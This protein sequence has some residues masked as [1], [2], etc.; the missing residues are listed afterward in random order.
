MRAK[1]FAAIAATIAIV[2]LLA[3]GIATAAHRSTTGR[4]QHDRLVI[5]TLSLPGS[6]GYGVS[7][8]LTNRRKLK[9]TTFPEREQILA[10]LFELVSTEYRLDA[11][12][13]RGSNGIQ[14]SV[15]RF[16]RI[17]LRFVP[18]TKVERPAAPLGCK[19]DKETIQVGWFVGLV[20]FRGERG[21]T[22]VRSK[23]AFGTMTNAPSPNK[24]CAKETGRKPQERSPPQRTRA[25]LITMARRAA[26]PGAHLLALGA[27]ATAGNRTVGFG[28]VR[29]SA[30]RK[31]KEFAIDTF[32]GTAR[33]DRGRIQ[34]QGTAFALLVR[35]PYFRVPDLT[36]MTS[37]AALAPPKPFRGDATYRRESADQVSWAGD[38]R[39]DLPGFGVVPL[40][41]PTFKTAM[42]LDSGCR[43]KK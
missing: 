33:R 5:A 11:P 32:L 21:Y 18:E 26:K 41:G 39:V 25:A 31:G 17:D 1:A 37:E 4:R 3:P 9:V 16:G 14:A 30:S 28:A 40:A 35:G 15:G 43:P 6:N 24:N 36:R 42:C 19:G 38:L 20:A 23:K 8:T 27:T 13:P 2:A 12:Q 7:V 10:H 34:E 29:L 22:R